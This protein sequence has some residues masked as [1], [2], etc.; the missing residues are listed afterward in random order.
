[1]EDANILLAVGFR[2]KRKATAVDQTPK[3][4]IEKSGPHA[5]G[6]ISRRTFLMSLD[7]V[8]ELHRIPASIAPL[9][10]V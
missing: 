7:T 3:I 5:P 4:T 1:M 6:Y 8:V 9:G 10:L 2:V